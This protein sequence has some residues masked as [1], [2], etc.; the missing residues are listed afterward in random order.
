MEGSSPPTKAN[1]NLCQ[2]GLKDLGIKAINLVLSKLKCANN[3]APN[4]C[5]S[6]SFHIILC[7]K[8]LTVLY[9]PDRADLLWR[10]HRHFA[11]VKADFILFGWTVGNVSP[12]QFEYASENRSPV[13]RRCQAQPTTLSSE[14]FDGSGRLL[15]A[16]LGKVFREKSLIKSQ[17]RLN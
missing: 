2:R 13:Q 9:H 5:C 12:F 10:I 11:T 16:L 15:L 7:H 6:I 17:Q 3:L 1:L 8:E 4:A 14:A